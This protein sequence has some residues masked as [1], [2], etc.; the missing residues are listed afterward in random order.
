MQKT[1]ILQIVRLMTAPETPRTPTVV[2]PFSA[3]EI[4]IGWNTGQSFAVPY[5]ELRYECPCAVCVDEKTGKRVIQR[6]SISP[7]I[8]VLGAQVIG[9]YALQ[10]NWSDRHSTGMYHFDTLYALCTRAGRGL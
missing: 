8:R 4:K 10:F 7:D 6:Q 5:F 3:T 2:E 9:R 1:A